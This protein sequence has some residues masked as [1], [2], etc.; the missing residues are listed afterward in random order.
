MG[1]KSRLLKGSESHSSRLFVLVTLGFFLLMAWLSIRRYIGFNAAMSDLGN[2]GQAIW[3]VTRGMPL[4]YTNINGQISRLGEHSELIFFLI[5]PIYAL[6]PS[7]ITLLVIQSGL[8]AAGG[9]AVFNLS[10]RKLK[11][12]SISL[13]LVAIYLLYPVAQTAVLFDFHG[14][15]LAMPLLLFAIDSLDRG[16]WR[17]YILWVI[18]AAM[19]KFYVIIPIV[20][21]G[22]VIFSLGKKRAGMLTIIGG[23]AWLFLVLS[24]RSHFSGITGMQNTKITSMVSYFIFYFGQLN[25]IRSSIGYRFVNLLIVLFPAILM[26]RQAFVWMIPASSI[27]IPVLLSTGPGPVFDYHF[28]HYALAVPFLLSAIIFG[29]DIIRGRE[30]ERSPAVNRRKSGR[31]WRG[32]IILTFIITLLFS[33]L[34]VQTPMSP[35]FY[36]YPY[37]G[38]LE[39]PARGVDSRDQLKEKWLSAYIPDD[40][41][42]LADVFLAPHLSNRK[43]LY[44]TFYTD[45]NLILSG[46]QLKTALRSVDFVAVDVFSNYFTPQVLQQVMQNPGFHLQDSRD[47]L[48]LFSHNR[49][50]FS[51]SLITYKKPN[52]HDSLWNFENRIGLINAKTAVLGERLIELEF[53]WVALSNLGEFPPLLA[54]SRLDPAEE[55]RIVHLPTSALYPTRQWAVGQVIHEDLTLV[56][57][58]SVP[59]GKYSTKV[60]W[61]DMSS[62]YL[63]FTD[64]RSRIGDEYDLGE[65]VIK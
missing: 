18:L 36:A 51:Y 60:G 16:A 31:S 29:A 39:T 15:T 30:E 56:I 19:C 58:N 6:F 50:D 55:T 7:P 9:L 63:R 38:S 2:M 22:V 61:Y 64:Y 1:I 47:G 59:P 24:L 20:I 25:Q 8:Y 32:D 5:A 35:T 45:G 11:V 52:Y 42:V 65:I 40:A 62:P 28:H 46:E 33:V 27:I 10:K 54:V 12:S 21:L 57:E 4:V 14:D 44:T 48:L 17:S 37:P 23:M 34:F 41:P 53:D 13:L 43:I 26:G 49:S 3:S